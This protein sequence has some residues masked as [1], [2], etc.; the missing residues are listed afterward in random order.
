MEKLIIKTK[1]DC[2]SYLE[3]VLNGGHYIGAADIKE[4]PE[5]G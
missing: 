2:E 1:V 4:G 5:P 3:L